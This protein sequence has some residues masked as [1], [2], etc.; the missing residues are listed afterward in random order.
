[1]PVVRFPCPSTP[2][3]KIAGLENF[4]RSKALSVRFAGQPAAAVRWARDA[5]PTEVDLALTADDVLNL[6]AVRRLIADASQKGDSKQAM[7]LEAVA[8]RLF[9]AINTTG[10]KHRIRGWRQ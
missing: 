5:S 8:A 4:A 1:M 6:I 7:Q 9:V 2:A 3:A 10:R